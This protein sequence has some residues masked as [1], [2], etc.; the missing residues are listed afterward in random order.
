MTAA[1]PAHLAA[2]ALLTTMLLA[3]GAVAATHIYSYDPADAATRDAAGPLT[4]QVHKPLIGPARLLNLRSTVAAADA[5]LKPATARDLGPGG[6]AALV[7]PRAAERQIY[8]IAPTDQGAALISALCP[9]AKRAWMAFSGLGFNE[10]LKVAVMGA[11][12]APSKTRLCRTLA[13]DFHG[14]WSG[15]PSTPV[16]QDGDSL[17][18][19]S[20]G[21]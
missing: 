18:G 19:R 8:E 20:S 4:F 6:L 14:E 2:A 9:G 13:Y 3:G 21:P 10:P 17:M 12:A 15:P 7:G 16:V 5:D 11:A 1:G